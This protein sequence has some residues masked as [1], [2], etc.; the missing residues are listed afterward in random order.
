MYMSSKANNE[1]YTLKEMLQ[2]PD[3]KKFIEAM[4]AE[5][6]SMFDEGIWKQVPRKNMIRFYGEQKAKLNR[7]N[8]NRS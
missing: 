6:Q 5:V 1:V 8:G 3:R 7:S 4:E 2:Q